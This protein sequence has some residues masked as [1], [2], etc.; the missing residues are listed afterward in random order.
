MNALVLRTI[1]VSL[2]FPSLAFAGAKNTSRTA[3]AVSPEMVRLADA[4]VGHWKNVETMERSKFFPTGG[5]R[6]GLSSCRLATGGTNLVC[7]GDSNGSAGPLHHLIVIWWDRPARVYRFFTCF[8]EGK[9]SSCKVRGTA[10]WEGDDF[11]NDYAEQVDGKTVKMRDSFI[12]IRP[13]SHVLVAA[14]EDS[15][16]HLTT[17]ITT[18]STRR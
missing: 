3:G 11:V 6:T 4:L 12:H 7:E 8:Q 9:E 15:P 13:D 18:R 16:G 14:I 17:V 5:E 10:H 2:L 1:G